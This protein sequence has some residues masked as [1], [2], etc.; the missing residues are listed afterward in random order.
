MSGGNRPD[1][2][3]QGQSVAYPRPV[4]HRD[5]NLRPS[6]Y[7]SRSG[8]LAGAVG[9]TYDSRTAMTTTRTTT[10]SRQKEQPW[11]QAQ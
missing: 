3:I 5:W 9:G 10:R 7:G 1:G 2:E 6:A 11:R 8:L 4:I